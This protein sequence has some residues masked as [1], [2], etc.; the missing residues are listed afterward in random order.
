MLKEAHVL[1]G[2]GEDVVVGLV[3]THNRPETDALLEGLDWKRVY[4]R[5]V[6]RPQLA[7]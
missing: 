5:R 2:R 6:P 3:E 7:Q 4:S 1:K